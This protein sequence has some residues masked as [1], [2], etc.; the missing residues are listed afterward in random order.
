MR[1]L[2]LPVRAARR[3]CWVCL[4]AGL[5]LPAVSC[6][7]TPTS[8]EHVEVTGTVSYKGKPVTGGQIS[9]VT[10]ENAFTSNGIIDEQGHYSIKAPVGDVKIAVNTEM[11]N[12]SAAGSHM[13]GATK[14]AGRPDSGE[15]SPI[16]GTYVAVPK[17]YRTADTSDLTYTVK[18]ELTQTH[19]V[20]LKD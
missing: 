3:A 14:G 18:K 5:L 11:L 7:R 9:F 1:R 8:A 10:V 17:K 15:P 20:E 2:V 16:K 13:Q 12:P 19:D 6:K 4:L